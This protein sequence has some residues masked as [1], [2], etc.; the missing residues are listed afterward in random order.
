MP[1]A[2]PLAGAYLAAWAEPHLY[3]S[4]AVQ[5]HEVGGHLGRDFD[6]LGFQL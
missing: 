2:E 1:T 3:K 6:L 5:N 4:V